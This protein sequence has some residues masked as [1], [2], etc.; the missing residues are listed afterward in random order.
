MKIFV[1]SENP[2]KIEAVRLGFAAM[3]P[4]EELIVTGK[5]YD[6][7]V[8]DQ[9]MTDAETYQGA[10][11]R[12]ETARV[13]HADQDYWVSVEGGVEF[14]GDELETFAWVIVV[15]AADKRG[16]A[17]TGSF[18]LPER[19]AELIKEGKELGEA[20]DIVFGLENSKQKTGAVGLLTQGVMDR[21]HYYTTAVILA[22]I[23][24]KSSNL[25]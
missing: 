17:K 1:V 9:P 2:M 14:K 19:I 15:N 24:F 13:A 23:P 10:L 22:L 5:K 6:S 20:D 11:N 7:G 21:T 8:K 18:F 12:V 25:Y 3:F 4:G 16:K